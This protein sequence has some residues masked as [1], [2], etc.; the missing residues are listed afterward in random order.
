MEGERKD[1]VGW[2]RENPGKLLCSSFLYF[3]IVFPVIFKWM[4]CVFLLLCFY[5]VV[6]SLHGMVFGFV[7]A[8]ADLFTKR[9]VEPLGDIILPSVSL[10]VSLVSSGT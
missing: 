9:F 6:I 2:I 5:H 7:D 4:L 3:G 8:T 1:L 10:V